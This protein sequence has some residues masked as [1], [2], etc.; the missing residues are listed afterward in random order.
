MLIRRAAQAA[1]STRLVPADTEVPGV[2][3]EE[4][5]EKGQKMERIVACIDGA[6]RGVLQQ[7][8]V[9]PPPPGQVQVEVSAS[10]ISPGTELGRVGAMRQDPKPEAAARA[11]GY[12]CAGKV[13]RVGEG[14]D[15]GM[16]GSRVAC[17]GAGYAQH[18]S[19]NNVP[20]NLTA[21]VPDTVT[22]EQAAFAHLAATALHAIRRAAPV[23]GENAMVAGLGLVG[24][25]S[26]QFAQASGGHAMGVDRL[27]MRVEVARACGVEAVVDA[28]T[29]DPVATAADV[30]GG[31]GMDYG[32]IA[33]GGDATPAFE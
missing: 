23:F 9:T 22:D 3:R 20:V 15:A 12:A 7:E 24:Q 11:F 5:L 16:I 18:A 33:F 8:G 32:V 10:L 2:R 6:G 31:W 28:S 17:M 25:M 30:S 4:G 19:I 29:Q 1:Y 26:S 14:V 21:T 27:A 13:I